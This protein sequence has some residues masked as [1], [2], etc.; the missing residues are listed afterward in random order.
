MSYQ[1]YRARVIVPA[2]KDAYS[3]AQMHGYIPPKQLSAFQH[4]LIDTLTINP[5]NW[6][7]Q[8]RGPDRRPEWGLSSDWTDMA[9]FQYLFCCHRGAQFSTDCRKCFSFGSKA[10]NLSQ[11]TFKLSAMSDPSAVQGISFFNCLTEQQAGVC[12]GDVELAFNLLAC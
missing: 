6:F 4:H 11:I 2:D 3:I 7:R 10:H 8:V 1:G 12:W 5:C 9:I